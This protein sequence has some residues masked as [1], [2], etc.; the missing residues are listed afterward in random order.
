[1]TS[2]GWVQRLAGGERAA[3]GSLP[4]QQKG[5]GVQVSVL[6]TLPLPSGLWELPGPSAVFY[7]A[8]SMLSV[9]WE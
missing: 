6:L 1:M 3:C 4:D 8:N 2:G 9:P 7:P 5:A